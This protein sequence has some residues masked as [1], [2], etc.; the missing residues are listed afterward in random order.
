MPSHHRHYSLQTPAVDAT[1]YLTKPPHLPKY[2]YAPATCDVSVPESC[3]CRAAQVV[4]SPA[5][6][7]IQTRVRSGPHLQEGGGVSEA[8]LSEHQLI[9]CSLSAVAQPV[10]GVAARCDHCAGQVDDGGCLED[11]ALRR[12]ADEGP[13]TC[14]EL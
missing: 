7:Q 12:G 3:L 14:A 5:D 4:S 1:R 6:H 11:W 13:G 8:R 10:E 9:C 2:A